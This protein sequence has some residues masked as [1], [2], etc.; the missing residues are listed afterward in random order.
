VQVDV[1]LIAA[2]NDPAELVQA[3]R[4]SEDLYYRLKVVTLTIALARP[5]VR[6]LPVAKHLLAA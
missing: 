2:A 3:K 6:H 1:S 4:F 5:P